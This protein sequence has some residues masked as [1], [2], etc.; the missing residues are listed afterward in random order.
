MACQRGRRDRHVRAREAQRSP[1]QKREE[2]TSHRLGWALRRSVAMH[3]GGE[4]GESATK[5]GACGQADD[6]FFWTILG[7]GL[8][9]RSIRGGLE[10]ATSARL[11]ALRFDRGR[12]GYACSRYGK[13]GADDLQTC[14][15][16]PSSRCQMDQSRVR[17]LDAPGC[18][19]L[20]PKPSTPGPDIFRHGR[21]DNSIASVFVD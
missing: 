11:S 21:G 5:G 19:G 7:S 13:D 12:S 16:A 1:E 20:L 9:G 4:G 6:G 14:L 15:L 17:P 8:G 10:D 3:R 18:F 2:N